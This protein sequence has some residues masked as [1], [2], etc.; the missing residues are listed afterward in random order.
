MKMSKL[1]ML[2]ESI[3]TFFYIYL[4][5]D[6]TYVKIFQNGNDIFHST[7]HI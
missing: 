7:E 6:K 1:Y 3:L 5:K 4:Y 2:M